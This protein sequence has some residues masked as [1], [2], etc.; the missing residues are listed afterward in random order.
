[1]RD[2]IERAPENW[3][4]DDDKF[5]NWLAYKPETRI[6]PGRRSGG[7]EQK[8]KDRMNLSSKAIYA[9]DTMFVLG[10]AQQI[11]KAGC[12]NLRAIHEQTGLSMKYGEAIAQALRSAGLIRAMRGRGGGY[13]LARPAKEITILAIVESVDGET[14]KD[15]P[16]MGQASTE[17]N[18]RLRVLIAECLR[19]YTLEELV[20]AR[21]SR[22]N[23]RKA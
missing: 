6:G 1:M 3:V 22:D 7:Q 17:I 10:K 8:E 13:L 21:N 12:I 2:V 19:G 4:I 15:R 18:S 23:K 11:D 5:D 16:Q 9:I 20:T 14:M